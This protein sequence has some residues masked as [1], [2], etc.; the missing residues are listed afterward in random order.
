MLLPATREWLARAPLERRKRFGQ[1]FTPEPVRAALLDGLHLPPRATILDPACGTGEFLHE[2]A[3]R[4]P[5]ARL[6]GWEIDAE[7]AAI[8]R[9]Q[10][11]RAE[12]RRVDAL[13]EKASPSFDAVI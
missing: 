5:D 4:W 1:F 6:V 7:L 13:R 10:V 11:P 3:K 8:A 12:I 9:D 2:A